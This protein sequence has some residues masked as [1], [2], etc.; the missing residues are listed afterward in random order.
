MVLAILSS[1]VALQAQEKDSLIRKLDS[2][3]VK[4]DS[5]TKS[6]INNID[7]NNYNEN[8]RLTFSTYFITLAS[9]FKQHVTLPFKTSGKE[10]RKVASFGLIYAALSFADEPINKFAVD[11]RVRSPALVSANRFI[12]N[13]GG[14]AELYTLAALGTYGFIFKNEK[15]KA[16][17]LLATQAFLTSNTASAFLKFVSGRQRPNYIDPK[18]NDSEPAFH[19]PFYQ[20]RK[21]NGKKIESNRFTAFPS[22]HTTLAFAAATVFAMEYRDRPVIPILSYSV[23]SLIGL[24]RITENK[25]WP[26]DVL[27][28]AVLGHLSGRLVVNNYHRYSRL[29]SGQRRNTVSLAMQSVNGRLLPGFIY[30]F[31]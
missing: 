10:W 31:H 9:S 23:A 18:E 16:T 21:D 24:S 30:R 6:K 17:T 1:S 15:I 2:L 20:F 26:T 4:E 11:L 5:L 22:G 19:G 27:V 29:K 3:A 12:T 28:G 14:T 13:T 25:H 8:T 7:Q